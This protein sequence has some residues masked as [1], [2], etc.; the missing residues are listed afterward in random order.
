MVENINDVEMYKYYDMVQNTRLITNA[1]FE[2]VSPKI[3]IVNHGKY[4]WLNGYQF[5]TFYVQKNNYISK[6]LIFEYNEVSVN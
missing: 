4:T 3:I 1:K 2:L 5:K 6:E